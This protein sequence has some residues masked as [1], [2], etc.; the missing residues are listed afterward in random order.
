MVIRRCARLLV[1]F[2]IVWGC[3]PFQ[4]TRDLNE[5][6]QLKGKCVRL[7]RPMGLFSSRGEK[8]ADAFI[9]NA[10]ESQ[11]RLAI[12]RPGAEIVIT[13]ILYEKSFEY[14]R[15]VVLGRVG[16]TRRDVIISRVFDSSWLNE[17]MPSFDHTST[18]TKGRSNPLNSNIAEWCH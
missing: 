7:L 14:D 1:A 5:F 9:G 8:L 3:E 2:L 16:K 4:E 15:V 17:A 10:N 6:F 11:S 13:R 12:L 18:P